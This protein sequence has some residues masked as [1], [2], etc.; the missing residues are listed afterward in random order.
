M[1]QVHVYNP[2]GEQTRSIE[3]DP[4]KLG[5]DVRPGLL[6]QA[7]VRYHANKRPTNSPT[8]TRGMVRGSGK[9]LYKQKG[10]GNARRGDKKANVLRGGGS[11]KAKTPHSWRLDMPTKMRRLANRNAILAKAVDGEIKLVEGLS[12]DKPNTKQ[13]KAVLAALNIDRTCLV[14][15]GDTRGP[16]ATSARNLEHT[17]VTGVDRLN[18]YDL[19]SHRYLV[20]EAEA[21][22]SYIAKVTEGVKLQEVT[23]EQV[24]AQTETAGEAA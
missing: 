21:F 18:V 5:G 14:A 10:T 4:A 19:L 9:K 1:I 24:A 7:Y 23:A 17:D 11:A 16:A 22:E 13:F 12:F 8:K 3:L 2:Q 15:L 6:K 20:A